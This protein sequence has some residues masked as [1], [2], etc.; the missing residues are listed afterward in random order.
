[1]KLVSHYLQQ[2]EGIAIFPIISLIIFMS[3]FV[4]AS[5]YALKMRKDQVQYMSNMPLEDDELDHQDINL[6]N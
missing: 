2:I 4:L 5:W 6:L 1:M 3:V